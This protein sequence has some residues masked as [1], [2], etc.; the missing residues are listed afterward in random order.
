MI[1]TGIEWGN[2]AD[3]L[4]GIG[5]LLAVVVALLFPYINKL[6]IEKQQRKVSMRICYLKLNNLFNFI[7]TSSLVLRREWGIKNSNNIDVVSLNIWLD[8][9]IT[10][11][12]NILLEALENYRLLYPESKKP[13]IFY[14]ECDRHVREK[15]MI[16]KSMA[17]Y[18]Y[19]ENSQK[20]YFLKNQTD[21]KKQIN[22]CLA[23]MMA[24]TANGN[25]IIENDDA[26][27]TLVKEILELKRNI[28]D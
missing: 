5:S 2:V 3:W 4:S 22:R 16:L 10:T 17:L 13:Y 11:S 21:L 1:L 23:G 19:D 18:D 26:N 12:D 25:M 7:S 14:D 20:D 9:F 27:S 24:V 8:D 28:R 6:K 15:I